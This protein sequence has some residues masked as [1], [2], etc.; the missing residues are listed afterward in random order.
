MHIN[1]DAPVTCHAETTIAAPA[2]TVWGLLS[3]IDDWPRWNDDIKAATLSGPLAPASTFRWKSGPGTVTST[4]HVVEPQNELGWSGRAFGL[5][6]SHLWRLTETD[7]HTTIVTEE[8]MEGPLARL[9]PGQIR[10]MVDRSLDSWLAA[11]K[12]EAERPTGRE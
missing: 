3:N 9:L 12:T 6:A 11:L 1:Q 10:K 7:G 4:L 2:A 5:Q 8:S